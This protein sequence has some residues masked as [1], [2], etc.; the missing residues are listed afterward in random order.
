STEYSVWG[1]DLSG[2]LQGA[3][4]IGG[5]L[6]R[7]TDSG[8]FLYLY[9]ANGNVDQLV[10]AA[11]GSLA[12]H[13]EYD[14]FGK[15]LAASGPEADNNPFRFSTKYFD[16]ETGL[17]Y[18]GYRYYSPELGRWIHRDPI[19]ESGGQNLYG[20]AGNDPIGGIDVVG[21]F[22]PGGTPYT[23]SRFGKGNST[24]DKAVWLAGKSGALT[25]GAATFGR[26]AMLA[27]YAMNH[28][29]CTSNDLEPGTPHK[30]WR[31]SQ[32][33][34]SLL[35]RQVKSNLITLDSKMKFSDW[36][37]AYLYRNYLRRSENSYFLRIPEKE[38]TFKKPSDGYY[39]FKNADLWFTG[40]VH[41]SKKKGCILFRVEM[42]VDF[43]D[44]YTFISKF[45]NRF[46]ENNLLKPTSIGNRLERAG[47]IQPFEVRET[48][49]MEETYEVSY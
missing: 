38:F 8:S 37:K 2:S 27:Y 7:N 17:Y 47:Y 13:Y 45:H 9:D 40:M 16:A 18:Y 14:P 48:W 20:F 22:C 42:N 35:K 49:R 19:E 12:A 36:F 32:M 33:Q 29:D 10:N 11:D 43:Y 5:L 39:A 44:L 41:V 46:G 26:G 23:E 25:T 1:L 4:G 28:A 34:C 30:R 3:G 24:F 31:L 21:L 15:L 6:L